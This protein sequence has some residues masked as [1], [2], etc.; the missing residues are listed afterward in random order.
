MNTSV[1]HVRQC[2]YSFLLEDP[3]LGRNIFSYCI[4]I[5]GLAEWNQIINFSLFLKCSGFREVKNISLCPKVHGRIIQGFS[6]RGK[7]GLIRLL[8]HLNYFHIFFCCI[9]SPSSEFQL[10]HLSWKL[11][12][13][14][15]AV[16]SPSLARLFFGLKNPI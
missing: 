12:V 14:Q 5:K 2:F 1:L 15:L 11:I 4:V 10:F 6:Y 13:P 9:L 8:L 16:L 3:S 7:A